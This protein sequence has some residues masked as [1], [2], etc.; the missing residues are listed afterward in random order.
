[1]AGIGHI[2]R[3]RKRCTHAVGVSGDIAAVDRAAVCVQRDGVGICFPFR[4]IFLVAHFCTAD[5]RNRRA[6]QIFVVIPALERVAGIVHIVRRRKCCTH[7]V[8]VSGDIAAVDRTAVRVQCYG[9]GVSKLR[10]ELGNVRRNVGT[11]RVELAVAVKP[12]KVTACIS[13]GAGQTIGYGSGKL[14]AV[15][16]DDLNSIGAAAQLA[17]AKVKGN[18]LQSV[19]TQC[20]SVQDFKDGAETDVRDG[21]RSIVVV[22]G[23]GRIVPANRTLQRAAR[24]NILSPRIYYIPVLDISDVLVQHRVPFVALGHAG[25]GIARTCI[26][27]SHRRCAQGIVHAAGDIVLAENQTCAIQVTPANRTRYDTVRHK[28]AVGVFILLCICL[29]RCHHRR[30]FVGFY[31][32]GISKGNIV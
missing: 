22:P 5:C 31:R 32:S 19:R 25:I 28:Q 18:D 23:E 24:K 30:E 10:R 13:I 3:C 20:V 16:H 7:A 4:P 2:A 29:S 12:H 8:G 17:A 27:T 21:F 14:A 11:G 9:V 1:M 15:F 6:G 26:V